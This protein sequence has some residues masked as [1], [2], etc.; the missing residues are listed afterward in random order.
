[1]LTV[2]ISNACAI[3]RHASRIGVAV[4]VMGWL[5]GCAAPR[6]KLQVLPSPAAEMT[7][8]EI[9][10]ADAP[11]DT[12]VASPVPVPSALANADAV[13]APVLMDAAQQAQ[14]QQAGDALHAGDWPLAESLFSGLR[15]QGVIS[16]PVV[17]GL[18]RALHRQQRHEAALDVLL[19]AEK[20]LP[21]AVQLPALRGVLLRESGRYDAAREAYLQALNIDSMHAPTHRNLAVL[22]DVYLGLSTLAFKHLEQARR[23]QADPSSD[24]WFTDLQRRVKAAGAGEKNNEP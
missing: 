22:A 24:A 16:L 5:G 6:E 15:E 14:L 9:A 19:D 11:A 10:K 8:A 18:A 12:P 2:S 4:A 17:L 7:N 1:M 23:L 20:Q 21:K 3:C 13:S